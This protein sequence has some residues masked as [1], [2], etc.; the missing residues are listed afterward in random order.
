MKHTC[1]KT[2]IAAVSLSVCACVHECVCVSMYMYNG[3][4]IP[5]GSNLPRDELIISV[6]ITVR[7]VKA[8]KGNIIKD[9]YC[10]V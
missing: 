3:M 2:H 9:K 4:I 5:A 10:V 8:V 1:F 6:Y 7:R